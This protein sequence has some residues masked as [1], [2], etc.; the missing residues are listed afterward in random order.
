MHAVPVITGLPLLAVAWVALKLRRPRSRL[1]RAAILA[2]VFG[3]VLITAG[4]AG[5]GTIV[6]GLGAVGA[7]T[8]LHREAARDLR[9]RPARRTRPTPLSR[10]PSTATAK[11]QRE[12]EHPA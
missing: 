11:P 1:G 5:P 2:A 4:V 7:A 6:L 8:C 3:D 10:Q 9:P 12:A